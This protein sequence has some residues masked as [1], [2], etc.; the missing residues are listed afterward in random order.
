MPYSRV[1]DRDWW[2]SDSNSSRYNTHQICSADS[3][4]FDT[5]AGENL[6]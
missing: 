2:V 1:G 5:A 3:C 4:P 6:Y